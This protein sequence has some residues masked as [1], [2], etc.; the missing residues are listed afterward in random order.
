M[1]LYQRIQFW[2][3]TFVALFVT[4][5]ANAAAAVDNPRPFVVP[6]LTS[7]Q[8][9]RGEFHPTGR[10]VVTDRAF[11]PVAERFAADYA[12]LFSR[13]LSVVQGKGRAGDIV[14]ARADRRDTLGAEGYRLAVGETATITAATA[15]GAFWGT[16]TILQIS[17]Q[18]RSHALPCGVA[19]DRPAYP[20]RGFMIDVG[21]KYIP[22]DYLRQLVKVMA[23]YKMNTLQ[24]HL[25]DNG[26][27][28]YFG[29][30]WAK[31]PAAFRLES[32][33]FPGLTARDGSYTKKEFRAFQRE[34][35]AQGVEILPEIDVPAHSLAFTHYRPSLGSEEFGADHLNLRNPAVV[36]FLD[37]LFT[38]YC[39]G[40]D[41]VFV[42]PRV[43]IGT[44]EY[45]NKDKAVVELF[46]SLTDHLIRHVERYGKQAVA[47]GALTHAHG[48]T[49]VKSKNVILEAWYN[50]YADPA[51]MKAQGYQLISI[52]DGYVYIVPAAGYYYDYLNCPMLY[53]K[54][55]PAQIGNQKFEEGDPAIL[56]GMFAV[57]NDHAGN[58]ITVR[59]IHHR[60][61]PALR[62]ISAKTWTGAAVSV[63]YA[64][65]TRRGAA[66]SEAP[67]VNLLGRLPGIAEG[68]ATLRCPRPVLQPNAPVD[69]VG[70]AVGYDYTVS[71]E[72]EADSVRRG[73]VLFSS[74]DATVYLAS[75]KNGKLAFE[76]EGYLNEFDYVVPAG[77]KVRLTFVGTNRETLLFV[78][79]RFRQALYPLTL[80]SASTD[81]GLAGASADPYAASKMYYQRTL[82]F[83]LARIGR[84]VGRIFDLSV[85]N[86]AEKY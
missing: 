47:W 59:D 37:S 84:F 60:V 77:R 8:G 56:G 51:K 72:L 81:A 55:T 79:G 43:H 29:N 40:P 68:R 27:K 24:V 34:A 14:L 66:L 48:D 33:F 21:R 41:P 35:A 22:M 61:M 50:G 30:D 64:E 86:Y 83:P 12:E 36:P 71:F 70:D 45:S 19:T 67:G 76:R 31:T 65:F 23:Y 53:E 17:E 49:P 82:V 28:Q 39:A 73:D 58:G 11:L 20:V 3:L 26:F 9:A 10:I 85:S 18:T 1:H 2:A 62:T 6:E 80:G 74:S 69:W 25:N 16:R 75:P 5:G 78:D 7:W 54:W 4:V 63:P 44:D 52:P 32:D 57:W 38:E 13:R 42:G 15:Q 46:R